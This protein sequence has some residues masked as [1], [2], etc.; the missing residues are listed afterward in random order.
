MENIATDPYWSNV[1]LMMNMEGSNNSTSFI[2]LKNEAVLT[3]LG[4]ARISTTQKKFGLSSACFD[5]TGDALRIP[6][7]VAFDPETQDFCFEVFVWLTSLKTGVIHLFGTYT[8][9]VVDGGTLNSGWQLGIKAD[10]KVSFGFGI[11]STFTTVISSTGA[12]ATGVFTHIAVERSNGIVTVYL[13]G[14]AS[15]SAASTHNIVMARSFFYVGGYNRGDSLAFHNDVSLTGYIDELR[16]T[17]GAARYKGNFTPP[18][19]PFPQ[20]QG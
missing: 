17:K 19:E 4:D 3:A 14:V 20:I 18:T 1:V 10:G 5:G 13:N 6:Y 12:V 16:L 9:G 8:Y 11:N 2:N 7:G 15:G